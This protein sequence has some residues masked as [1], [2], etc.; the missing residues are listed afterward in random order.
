MLVKHGATLL[1]RNQPAL[2]VFASRGYEPDF[3]CLFLDH[4]DTEVTSQAL[5]C[6][7]QY[8]IPE[9]FY[10]ALS[11]PELNAS[12]PDPSDGKT[13]LHY[14][15]SSGNKGFVEELLARSDVDVTAQDKKGQTPLLCAATCGVALIVDL[16]LKQPG[17][18]ILATDKS[19]CTI[20]HYACEA[21]GD[22]ASMRLL[23]ERLI[24]VGV[25][26]NHSSQTG[27]ALFHALKHGNLHTALFLISKGADPTVGRQVDKSGWTM[28]H[29][30]LYKKE[31]M[32]IRTQLVREIVSRGA[33][34][35]HDAE[36]D[37]EILLG[38]DLEN[39]WMYLGPPL[40]FAAAYAESVECMKILIDAGADP[41]Y[42]ALCVGH[43]DADTISS[44]DVHPALCALFQMCLFE[45]CPVQRGGNIEQLRERVCLLLD[46]GYSLD[47]GGTGNSAGCPLVW[48]ERLHYPQAAKLIL[49]YAS[50]KNIT[51]GHLMHHV[52]QLENDDRT[53]SQEIWRMLVDFRHREYLG[54][55]SDEDQDYHLDDCVQNEEEEQED[56]E[57]EDEEEEED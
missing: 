14:A 25:D 8:N 19:G 12:K 41:S 43:D 54:C 26:V 17:V 30:S 27:T 52:R 13:A 21:D 45:K 38:K 31:C 46:H 35:E 49:D 28:L 9:L 15:A 29:H 34:L 57:E 47:F 37:A 51:F 24:E 33:N 55:E 11:K 5:R 48:A 56:E 22:T 6:A 40:H 39:E 16:I 53:E 10:G 23:I 1:R 3:L 18:D 36:Y 20:L 44:G 42:G 32:E 7:A 50:S 4:H 2:P